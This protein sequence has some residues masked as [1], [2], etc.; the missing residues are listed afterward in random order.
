MARLVLVNPH[1][2]KRRG[3][4]GAYIPLCLYTRIV[5]SLV[6]ANSDGTVVSSPLAILIVIVGI[7]NL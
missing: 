5:F 4:G 6:C 3:V 2:K 1:K 7:K